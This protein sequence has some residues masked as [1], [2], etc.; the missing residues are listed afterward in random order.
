MNSDIVVGN[1]EPQYKMNIIN[2]NTV[3]EPEW[4]A[5]VMNYNKS[6]SNLCIYDGAKTQDLLWEL[7]LNH[8]I[9]IKKNQNHLLVYLYEDAEENAQHI[10]AFAVVNLNKTALYKIVEISLLCSSVPRI[11]SS[12]VSDTDR[13][14]QHVPIKK[15]PRKNF[16]MPLGMYLLDYIF[17]NYADPNY[18]LVLEPASSGLV[19]Y[20]K[21][22]KTPLLPDSYYEKD[23]TYEK[24]VFGDIA[25]VTEENAP[26]LMEDFKKIDE[27]LYKLKI[28]KEEYAKVAKKKE[29]LRTK[30]KKS[31]YE[32]D[33]KGFL[34][35][36]LDE[37]DVFSYDK[38]ISDI[39]KKQR[40]VKSSQKKTKTIKP[41]SKSK[42]LSKKSK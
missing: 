26:E 22:W 17:M 8:S 14:P 33:Y 34:M 37:I 38:F 6:K 28:N 9:L 12:H 16:G 15:S 4:N 29:F 10:V 39:M 19:T 35:S 18:L 23:K 13:S 30:I 25:N 20:Y 1:I 32:E 42:T 3:T 5:F 27:L 41:N 7:S 2:T 24:L 11:D 21:K 40:P 31:Q 36:H